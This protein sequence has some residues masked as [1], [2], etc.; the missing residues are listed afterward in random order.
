MNSKRINLH[1]VIYIA[2]GVTVALYTIMSIRFTRKLQN[3]NRELY[4]YINYTTNMTGG[5][6][7]D[8]IHKNTFSTTNTLTYCFSEYMCEECIQQDLDVLSQFQPQFEKPIFIIAAIDKKDRTHRIF[9][10]NRLN[11]FKYKF[12]DVDSIKFP[13]HQRDGIEQ[14]FFAYTNDIGKPTALFFPLKNKQQWSFIYLEQI[15]DLIKRQ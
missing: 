9:W 2:I 8:N 12:V 15:K 3:E 1:L 14:R 4:S 5:V 11:H 13:E 6:N 10:E 7:I